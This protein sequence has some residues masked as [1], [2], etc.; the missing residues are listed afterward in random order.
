[1]VA[2]EIRSDVIQDGFPIF[3]RTEI[4]LPISVLFDGSCVEKSP[5]SRPEKR[6]LVTRATGRRFSR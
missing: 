5:S 2:I 4:C 1:M 3:A 6:E